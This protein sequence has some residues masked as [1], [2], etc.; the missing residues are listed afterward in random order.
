[1][2]K[3]RKGK[4]LT[5]NYPSGGRSVLD[6]KHAG[7]GDAYDA[8]GKFLGFGSRAAIEFAAAHGRV[9]DARCSEVSELSVWELWND[10]VFNCGAD[11]MQSED[12]SQI[13]CVAEDI[14][15]RVEK[16]EDGW[17]VEWLVTGDLESRYW[18]A[19]NGCYSLVY[20]TNPF[21]LQ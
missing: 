8:R 15:L 17:T 12:G 14:Y 9:I 18:D 19:V 7:Q 3:T 20:A 5:T 11:V 1:M 6:A 10:A 2:A 13:M 16:D 4:S 21:R